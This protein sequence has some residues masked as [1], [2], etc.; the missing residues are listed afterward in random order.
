[1]GEMYVVNSIGLSTD[2]CGTP[3]CTGMAVENAA[4]SRTETDLSDRYDATHVSA[5]PHI[6]NSD[7]RRL[8]RV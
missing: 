3:V 2:P 6:P 1:M 5:E 4:P 7:W 8:S